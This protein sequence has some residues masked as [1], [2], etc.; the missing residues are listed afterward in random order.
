[1]YK[2]IVCCFL[3]CC[4]SCQ[5]DG[6][7]IKK[8]AT[9]IDLGVFT[10]QNYNGK[11]IK[12]NIPNNWKYELKNISVSRQQQLSREQVKSNELPLNE[13]DEVTL[14]EAKENVTDP[15]ALKSNPIP[16]SIVCLIVNANKQETPELD[17]Y[18]EKFRAAMASRNKQTAIAQFHLS[19]TRAQKFNN[20]N[21]KVIDSEIK[22]PTIEGAENLV[23]KSKMLF[24]KNGDLIYRYSL[25]YS[26][27]EQ[28][29][30]I[31]KI[32]SSIAYK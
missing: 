28:L 32:I 14:F 3:L 11:L 26:K 30:E 5:Q 4:F 2:L 1:M 23:I 6:K 31:L 15:E 18:I 25:S 17:P 27:P 12:L 13:I 29:S 21:F 10:G 16:G 7:A 9:M 8:N 19:P 20:I 24:H 22:Y